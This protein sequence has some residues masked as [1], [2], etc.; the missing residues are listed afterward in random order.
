MLVC[1]VRIRF[2]S[3]AAAGEVHSKNKSQQSRQ[4]YTLKKVAT[5]IG[6]QLLGMEKHSSGHITHI[7][8]NTYILSYNTHSLVPL[9]L[10]FC[11]SFRINLDF[12][13]SH[14]WKV[15]RMDLHWTKR[16]ILCINGYICTLYTY[17]WL[18]YVE[19]RITRVFKIYEKHFMG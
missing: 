18:Y 19:V 14:P 13:L 5:Y 4:P 15:S 11:L 8:Y 12:H 6:R 3:T 1:L 9:L 10:V 17:A 7:I 16:R 2:S